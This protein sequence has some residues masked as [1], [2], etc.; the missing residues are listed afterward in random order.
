MQVLDHSPGMQLYTA[1]RLMNWIESLVAGLSPLDVWWF[2]V[3]QTYIKSL[4]LKA[5]WPCI[6]NCELRF[7]SE[8]KSPSK[9]ASV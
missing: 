6:T 5:K 1:G 7:Y 8:S 3:Q 2:M 4:M 9:P